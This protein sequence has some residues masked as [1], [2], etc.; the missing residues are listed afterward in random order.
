MVFL[1]TA[2][3]PGQM[4][5]ISQDLT[6]T[7]QFDALVQTA[8]QAF[9]TQTAFAMPT[10]SAGTLP[11]LPTPSCT[12]EITT[13]SAT[14][15]SSMP[16]SFPTEEP[17][18]E[19]TAGLSSEWEAIQAR[20]RVYGY[21]QQEQLS[22]EYRSELTRKLEQYGNA[23]N[24]LTLELHGDNYNMYDG[25]Y[26]LTP[27]AF[28]NQVDTLMSSDYHF[29]TLHE[30]EGFVQGWFPLPAR[31]VILTT[32][33]SSQT[34]DSLYSITQI[35]QELEKVHGYKPHMLVFP[36]TGDMV[37]RPGIACDADSCWQAL[38]DANSS[39][40]FTFGSHSTTHPDFATLT[41]QQAVKD[42]HGSSSEIADQMGLRVY[43]LAWPFEVCSADA[44]IIAELGFTLAWGGS[45]KPLEINYTAWQD[46]RPL[47]LP[48]LFPPAP[49]GVSMRPDGQTLQQ[50]L[51]GALS[52]P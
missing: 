15:P 19:P 30:V 36:W 29:A 47:C 40:Y 34:I 10:T 17:T 52:V 5:Q 3:M 48:R 33:I 1:V 39:G 21:V 9:V 24:I 32:D 18:L 35:F 41:T 12:P 26:S 28:Y 16:T 49:S 4:V 25:R 51:D 38:R 8:V 31:S 7:A 44:D 14:T 13:Q 46:P 27:E 2:C 50:M 23:G 45:T 11:T 6:S 22:D 37:E 20:M 42:L 43:A